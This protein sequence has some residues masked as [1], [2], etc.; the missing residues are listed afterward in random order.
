MEEEEEEDVSLFCGGN[1]IY[2]HPETIRPYFTPILGRDRI[3]VAS[4]HRKSRLFK[5]RP[6]IWRGVYPFYRFGE[7]F[8]PSPD[9]VRGSPFSP[10]LRG[11]WPI[12]RFGEGV[13]ISPFSARITPHTPI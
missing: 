8:A 1:Q 10:S 4:D 6:Q 13:T 12:P 2:N 7:D 11:F 5:G 9:S 3:E